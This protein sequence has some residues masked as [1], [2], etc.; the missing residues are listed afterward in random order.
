MMRI[1]FGVANVGHQ[2]G[3]RGFTYCLPPQQAAG[4]AP[5]GNFSTMYSSTV[6]AL[7]SVGESPKMRSFS[8]RSSREAHCASL[9]RIGVWRAEC[10]VWCLF[11][12]SFRN[13]CTYPWSGE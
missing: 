3:Q 9:Q 10:S 1:R 4:M 8:K 5:I 12:K 6:Q 2:A 7:V 13:T 11:L